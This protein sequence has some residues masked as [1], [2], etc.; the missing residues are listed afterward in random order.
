MNLHSQTPHLQVIDPRSLQLREV[1]YCRNDQNAPAQQRVTRQTWDVARRPVA[2]WDPR[3][4]A[5]GFAANT[6][7]ISSL[8]GQ[9]LLEDSVDAGWRLALAGADGQ[10]LDRWDGRG[11]HSRTDFDALLRPVSVAETS[12][13]A[14]PAVV[15][16][17]RY[18][19]AS[20][21][22]VLHNQCGRLIRHDDPA[23]TRIGQAFGLMGD[24]IRQNRRFLPSEQTPDWPLEVQNRDQLLE[25]SEG[26]TTAALFDAAARLI[27]QTDAAGNVSTHRHTLSGLLK[28]T[29]VQLAGSVN[30]QTLVS[31]IH[32][33]VQNRVESER[34]GN[35]V[36]SE[37]T[38]EP[39]SG[40]LTRIHAHRADGAV[41][42][43]LNYQ[44]DPVG[45]ILETE[46]TSQ[47]TVY[48]SNQKIDPV[49]R[50]TYDS[51]YQLIE[52]TGREVSTGASHGPALP[53]LQN[54]PMDPNQLSNYTQTYD[55]D[56]GGNLLQMR[57]VGAR[58][59]TRT[60]L[61]APGSDR[62]LAKGE[63]DA[64]FENGFDANGNLQ[65]LVR[66]QSMCWDLRNQLRRVTAIAREDGVNDEEVYVYDSAGQ[67]CRKI[68]RAEARGQT[69]LSEVRYL[70]GIE[71][72]SQSTGEVLQVISIQAGR[73]SVRSLHWVEGKP[74]TIVNDQ[75]RY[76][77]SDHLNSATLELDDKGDLMSQETYY[78]FGGTS[79][80]AARNA[81]EAKYKTVRYSAQERDAS[82]LHYYGL[83]YY[84]PWLQRWINPDPKGNVDG[85]NVFCFVGNRPISRID[86]DGGMDADPN[87]M[88]A[89]MARLAAHNQTLGGRPASYIGALAPAQPWHPTS[90]PFAVPSARGVLDARVGVL[91]G[92]IDP[93]LPPPNALV[94]DYIAKNFDHDYEDN[95]DASETQISSDSSGNSD[96]SMDAFGDKHDYHDDHVEN[97]R[98]TRFRSMG[99]Y[100]ATSVRSN[101]EE[102][103]EEEDEF[104]VIFTPEKWTIVR[105]YK[106]SKS[107]D[108]FASD[109]ILYQYKKVSEMYGFAR[110]LPSAIEHDRLPRGPNFDK[111]HQLTSLSAEL[112]DVFLKQTSNGK[113]TQRIMDHFGMKPLSTRMRSDDQYLYITTNVRPPDWHISRIGARPSGM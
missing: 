70:P 6:T 72:R 22:L 100:L 103:E 4:W 14:L 93:V 82:G 25:S 42:Q 21:A 48:F 41:L 95:T 52:A 77:L 49:S 10:S 113:V 46:D 110:Q 107:R 8:C 71:I 89:I 27:S 50:Y 81:V 19:E 24:V 85:L 30:R 39:Q 80:W 7:V 53:D 91:W 12:G 73:S 96:E 51:L 58:S 54:L 13:Q 101:V 59:F 104:R 92:D 15:E 63:T 61:V 102:E 67:R 44:Y 97:A 84:A 35:G 69:L 11:S 55:Y 31:D 2:N 65:E 86:I 68:R 112:N 17:Y 87:S 66:G 23:G 60:M 26:Y 111:V 83:R 109:V 56:A 98:T 28:D 9:P 88:S 36:I 18:G 62:S 38:Y 75:L 106:E 43:D 40:R 45:N 34:L 29:S 94:E 76:T 1:A 74:G 3:L 108:Y 99:G 90:N 47:P 57:H 105:M 16:R 78:P 5:A 20:E 37:K 33:S 64:D 79:C 32:Y